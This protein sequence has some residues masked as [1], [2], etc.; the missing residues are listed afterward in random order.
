MK[1]LI[2][3]KEIECEG[4]DYVLSRLPWVSS[5]GLGLVC[6][7]PKP[8]SPVTAVDDFW[9]KGIS[10]LY[11]S[12]LRL[13]IDLVNANSDHPLANPDFQD[14][15]ES[16]FKK[17]LA[18]FTRAEKALA[19][20]SQIHGLDIFNSLPQKGRGKEEAA[21]WSLGPMPISNN[22]PV[23]PTKSVN[24]VIRWLLRHHYYTNLYRHDERGHRSRILWV[25][26]E[27]G[28]GKSLMLTAIARH[29]SGRLEE[30][31]CP[32][33][34]LYVSCSKQGSASFDAS[35]I[36]RGLIRALLSNQLLLRVH[37]Q[38]AYAST[39]RTDFGRANDFVALSGL[40]F[41]MVNDYIFNG[42]IFLIDD[43]DQCATES[44][45]P[46]AMRLLCMIA[47]STKETKN[48]S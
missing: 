2:L 38:N 6:P 30:A 42:A 5:F 47:S 26:G 10:T 27:M 14:F 29:L 40:L 43:I 4:L 20:T 32:A 8:A 28:S 3:G 31:E 17:N 18:R 23:Y 41:D 22:F 1:A 19:G 11:E 21:A 16:T 33:A 13:L 9:R 44:W 7:Q 48:L 46:M 37:L 15:D 36:L 24:H 35:T 45:F 12:T 34:L 25:T 39:G